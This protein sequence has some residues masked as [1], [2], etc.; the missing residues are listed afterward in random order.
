MLDECRSELEAINQHLT[1]ACE[2]LRD[3]YLAQLK[4]EDTG[5]YPAVPT[6]EWQSRNDGGDGLYLHF[7]GK[8]DGTYRG[9]EGQQ[10][11][12]IGT[13]PE[14]IA[15]ARRRV[16]NRRRYEQLLAAALDLHEWLCRYRD[17]LEVEAIIAKYWPRAEVLEPLLDDSNRNRTCRKYQPLEMFEVAQ[18][19]IDA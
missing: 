3:L 16:E 19:T 14:Q 17:Q 1:K 12:Y 5:L 13:D 10:T 11:I 2:Y 7:P 4:L 6:E 8:H 18:P 9:P 15:E